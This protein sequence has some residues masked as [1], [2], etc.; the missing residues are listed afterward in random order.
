[1]NNLSINLLAKIFVFFRVAQNTS[2]IS[3]QVRSIVSDKEPK[4]ED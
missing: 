3:V 1:L 2:T 4:S